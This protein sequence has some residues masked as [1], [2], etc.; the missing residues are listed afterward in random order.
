MEGWVD[1]GDRLHTEMVYPPTD[2]QPS[3]YL[4]NSA[5]PGVNSR[6]V[7]H[8]SDALT[9]KKKNGTIKAV[10]ERWLRKLNICPTWKISCGCPLGWGK[11]QLLHPDSNKSCWAEKQDAMLSQRW[12]RDAQYS[13]YGC[14]ENFWESLHSY[15]HLIVPT[16][17]MDFC[18]D[19][20][21]DCAYK[22]WSS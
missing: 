2:G 4:P 13:L 7:D 9:K 21:R 22:I 11:R 18:F 3:K 6:P 17:L 8:K 10:G 16:F 19:R 1:L 12:P 5:W 15:A 20:Y 14:S